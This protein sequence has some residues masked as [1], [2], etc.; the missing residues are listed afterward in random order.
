MNKF[1]ILTISSGAIAILLS[2]SCGKSGSKPTPTQTQPTSAWTVT[3]L[4]G[5]GVAGAANGL[6]TATSFNSPHGVA[7]DASGNIY[8]AD[9]KNNLIRKISF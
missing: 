4:A 5:S 3:T 1:S 2:A 9:T 6:G 8:V 7:T